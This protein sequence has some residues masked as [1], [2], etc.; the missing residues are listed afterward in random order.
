VRERETAFDRWEPDPVAAC[1]GDHGVGLDRAERI[2]GRAGLSDHGP[3]HGAKRCERRRVRGE[4]H[5]GG[6]IVGMA[7]RHAFS[8]TPAT[9][10]IDLGTLPGASI[11]IAYGVNDAGL[12]VGSSGTAASNLGHAVTWER[13]IEHGR[14]VARQGQPGGIRRHRM[15]V[16]LGP[17]TATGTQHP[18]HRNPA[19]A[20]RRWT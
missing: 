7:K 13:N 16:S 3:G 19:P 6:Q 1:P 20:Q 11:S 5:W 17:L 8:Y 14:D 15:P 10:M 2:A 9:G 12:I 4:W 18:A